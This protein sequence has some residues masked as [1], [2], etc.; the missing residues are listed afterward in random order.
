M[1]S[2]I[3]W[4]NGVI[5]HASATGSV[6]APISAYLEL[7]FTSAKCDESG[8]YRCRVVGSD[9]GSNILDN[10]DDTFIYA[11]GKYVCLKRAGY[12]GKY[13]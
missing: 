9:A 13:V 1:A 3:S 11:N 12:N 7:N 5:A 6:D 10:E 8:A 4:Q 2:V